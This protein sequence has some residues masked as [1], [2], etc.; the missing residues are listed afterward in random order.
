MEESCEGE[1]EE[2]SDSL[3]VSMACFAWSTLRPWCDFVNFVES[4][5]DAWFGPHVPPHLSGVRAFYPLGPSRT[6]PRSRKGSM[7]RGP[8]RMRAVDSFTKGAPYM[9]T[10]SRPWKL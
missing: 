10:G 4:M 2:E 3:I 9:L 8:F 1:E 5:S 7:I 6:V